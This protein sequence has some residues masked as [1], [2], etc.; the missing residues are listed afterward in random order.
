MTKHHWDLNSR[1]KVRYFYPDEL[2][3]TLKR[4]R[5]FVNDNT[6]EV[7][8]ISIGSSYIDDEVYFGASVVYTGWIDEEN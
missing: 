8:S 6:V 1:H 2:D 5:N 7:D 4:I 3:K